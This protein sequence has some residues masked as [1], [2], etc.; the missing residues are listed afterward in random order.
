[1]IKSSR[2]VNQVVVIGNGRKFPSVLI[3]PDWE[4]LE[5]YAK[6]KGL[7]LT[8]REEFCRHPR[9]ID[10]FAGQIAART[11]GLAR[12]EKIKRVALLPHELTVESDE[13]APSLKETRPVG[14][15]K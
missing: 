5:A 10:L 7:N 2:F 6:L 9:I 4:Q 13:L 14:E 8:E 1:M 3:V 15:D 11:P 12:F